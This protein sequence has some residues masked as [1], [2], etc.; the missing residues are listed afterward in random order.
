MKISATINN[1]LNENEIVVKT[2]EVSK[3]ISIAPKQ[4]GLGSSINGGELLLLASATCF[5]NDIYREAGKRNIQVSG[6][7]VEATADFGGEGEAGSNFKYR[8]KLTSD[9]SKDQIIS[10]IRNT[11]KVAE[12]HNTLRKGTTVSLVG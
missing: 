3:E 1:R 5:C 9:A 8:V 4:N 7:E 12:I 11:D 10:L 2:N 6:V